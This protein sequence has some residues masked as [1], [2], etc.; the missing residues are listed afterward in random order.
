MTQPHLF[1]FG[2]GYVAQHFAMHLLEKGWRVS[3]T[4]RTSHKIDEFRSKGVVVHLFDDDIPLEYPEEL[5]RATHVLHSIS[6]NEYGDPVFRQH[7]QDLQNARHIEWIGYLSTTGVYGDRQGQWVDETVEPAAF[8]ERTQRRIETEKNWLETN[9]PVHVFRL[10]GIYGPDRNVLEEVRCNRARRI[11][12]PGQY[13]SRIHVEDI[14]QILE[15][16]ITKPNPGS[17]YNCA[18]DAPEE[19]AVVTAYAAQLLGMQPP[20]LQNIEEANLSEMARSF[21]QTNRRVKNDKI[22][23]ELNVSLKYPNYQIGLEALLHTV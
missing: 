11:N 13:F 23:N 12:K 2:L 21:Y 7:L 14:A 10:A 8:N 9:L 16:S 22:K 15:A 3:G 4:S 17:I 18:D 6:P 19:Q 5:S 20:P 1:C